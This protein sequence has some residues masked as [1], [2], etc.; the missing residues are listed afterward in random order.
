MTID[1]FELIDFYKLTEEDKNLILDWRNHKDIRQW[2][3]TSE[4]LS[5]ENHLNFIESLKKSKDKRYFLVLDNQKK[6]GVIYFT[7]ISKTTNSSEFGLYANPKIQG[8]GAKLMNIICKYAFEELK[9]TSLI[10]EVFSSNV[11][12]ISLYSKYK[13]KEFKREKTNHQEVIYME[14]R[15]EIR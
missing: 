1:S 10:A 15:N 2:M 9:N 4:I 11:R 14:L 6:I 5:R 12:A 3:H 7:S 13:F 8:L